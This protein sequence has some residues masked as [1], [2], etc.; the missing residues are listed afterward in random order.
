MSIVARRAQ[1]EA[2]YTSFE[3]TFDDGT[4]QR[5]SMPPRDDD[6]DGKKFLA[7]TLANIEVRQ[8]RVRAERG[9]SF[10]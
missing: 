3:L 9:R 6:P 8:Q 4:T 1:H 10:V 7:R 5:V 2:G